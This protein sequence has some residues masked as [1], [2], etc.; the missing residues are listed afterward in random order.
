[1]NLQLFFFMILNNYPFSLIACEDVLNEAAQLTLKKNA[2][3]PFIFLV[4]GNIKKCL[5]FLSLY[6]YNKY[7]L[8]GLFIFRFQAYMQI[9]D[10][11]TF[12]K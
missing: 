8:T 11:C 4:V 2:T 5:C 10:T 3:C 6:M 1:M 7:N 9:F 12:L